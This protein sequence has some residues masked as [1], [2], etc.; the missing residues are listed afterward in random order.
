[1]VIYQIN[2]WG[3][4]HCE[5]VQRNLFANGYRWALH[6]QEIRYVENLKIFVNPATKQMRVVP[7]CWMGECYGIEVITLS[8]LL[9]L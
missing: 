5:I 4:T 7:T 9:H 1:M 3:S 2:C 6:G 8:Q